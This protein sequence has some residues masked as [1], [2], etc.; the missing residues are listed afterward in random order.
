M[1]KAFH[2]VS[3]KLIGYLFSSLHLMTGKITIKWAR[4]G[5][6]NIGDE[7]ILRI[8]I[9]VCVHTDFK[10]CAQLAIIERNIYLKM[11]HFSSVQSLSLV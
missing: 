10:S 1:D 4:G 6:N 8:Y 11:G 2:F 9:Y 7:V 5:I 3:M